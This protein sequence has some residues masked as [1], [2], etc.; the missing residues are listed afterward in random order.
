[1]IH[2]IAT[3]LPLDIASTLSPGILALVLFLL[4]SK[5]NGTKRT[6][7]LLAGAIFTAVCIAVA[8]FTLG[9]VG[10]HQGKPSL[11]SLIVD[12][13]LGFL[14]IVFG[15]KELISKENPISLKDDSNKVGFVKWFIIGFI[16]NITNFDAVLLSFTAAREVGRSTLVLFNKLA[17]VTFNM[18]FFILPITLPL[19]LTLL[20]PKIAHKFLTRLNVYVIKYS[21]YII[22]FLFIV[23]GIYLLSRVVKGI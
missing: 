7:A 12:C 11:F 1:M 9:S 20:F 2:L 16:I 14:L 22:A 3:V 18:S 23:F 10:V 21:K 13:F 19:F 4:G 5:K 17:I 8:G 6:L 15:I